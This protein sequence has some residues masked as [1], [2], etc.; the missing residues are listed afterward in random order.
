MNHAL[1]GSCPTVTVTLRG[2]VTEPATG[3]CPPAQQDDCHRPAQRKAL[4]MRLSQFQ[5]R[6]NNEPRHVH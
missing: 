5:S 1:N 4:L 3:D 6:A 2:T